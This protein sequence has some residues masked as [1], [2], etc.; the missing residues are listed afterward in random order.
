MTYDVND[1]AGNAATQV[2]R[3][4]TV[5]DTTIPIITLNGEAD[6][7]HDAAT[8]YSE[9]GATWTDTLDGNGTLDANGT[10]NVNAPGTYVLTYDVNDDAG[11]V[12]TQV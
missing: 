6:V 3:A 1:D 10:V 12:A 8:A 11:N 4:V 9:V 7:T 5:V 2:S